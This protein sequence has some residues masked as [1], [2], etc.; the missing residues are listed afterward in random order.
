MALILAVL[1]IGLGAWAQTQVSTEAELR[2]AIVNGDTWQTSPNVKLMADITL[3]DLY[4]LFVSPDNR[5]VTIDLN[6]HTL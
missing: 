4:P 5:G 6:G 3:A 2:A 1:A